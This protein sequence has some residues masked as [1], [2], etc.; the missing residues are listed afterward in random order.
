[1]KKLPVRCILFFSYL[2]LS[3]SCT[4]KKNTYKEIENYFLSRHTYQIADNKKAIYVL[5][6]GNC[7]NCSRS[8]SYLM[9]QKLS[10]TSCVFLV[11]NKGGGLDLSLFKESLTS[12]DLFFDQNIEHIK[13]VDPVLKKSSV[14]FLKNKS[15][16]TIIELKADMLQEQ[17]DFI[18]SH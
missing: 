5:A 4:S 3:I 12:K 11:T 6:E 13:G 16:D 14:I 10:D 8:L 18:I 17:M 7:I 15:I 2:F 9:E 1:M